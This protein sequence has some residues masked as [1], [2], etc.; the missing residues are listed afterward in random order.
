MLLN[1][2]QN[3]ICFYDVQLEVIAGQ[4]TRSASQRGA[5]Q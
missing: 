3:L 2:L 5:A 4:Q 1:S